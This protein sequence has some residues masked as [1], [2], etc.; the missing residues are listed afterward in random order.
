MHSNETV[1]K[2]L[3]KIII[4]IISEYPEQTLWSLI[5]VIKSNNYNRSWRG[6]E[7]L[8]KLRVRS[9]R[10]VPNL[11][12]TTRHSRE[13]IIKIGQHT[14][15]FAEALLKLCNFE[16][17]GRQATVSLSRGLGFPTHSVLPCPLVVPLQS[18]LTVILPSS[19]AQKGKKH[20]PF[21]LDQPTLQSILF[22]ILTVSIR[23]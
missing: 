9:L 5:A 22:Y 21:P 6:Q 13:E 7:I 12:V 1:L 20:N 18:N 19:N 8:Q 3:M 14:I 16:I 15:R 23:G 4:T 2:T 17:T 10:V 11:K